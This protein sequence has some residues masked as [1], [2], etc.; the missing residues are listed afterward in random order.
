VRL[1]S[2]SLVTFVDNRQEREA[3]EHL[4]RSKLV[5]KLPMTFLRPACDRL[6]VSIALIGL[7]LHTSRLGAA[8]PSNQGPIEV[9][10]I[11]LAKVQSGGQI[12]FVSSGK[13]LVRFQAI[14]NNPRTI[15]QFSTSDPRPT[16][17]VKLTE[18]KPIH[19]VSVVPGSDSQKVD[20]YLLDQLPR[21]PSDLDKI[22][23]LACIVGLIVGKE[24]SVDFPPQ[25]AWYVALRWTLPATAVGPLRIAE[26]GAFTQTEGRGVGATLMDADLPIQLVSGPP[27]IPPVS[28]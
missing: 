1:V 5:R 9:D 28:P 18:N 24:A 6:S 16:V 25:R 15:F 23:P 12:V 2:T 8:D 21:K 11:N 14:D 7:C 13:R 17:I 22:E 3:A 10:E 19:R 26:I 20:V 27:L 4:A